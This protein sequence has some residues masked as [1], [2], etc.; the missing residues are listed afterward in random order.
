M[1]PTSD[2]SQKD[3][4]YR[5]VLG[6]VFAIGFLVRLYAYHHTYIINPDGILYI[7]QARAIFNGQWAEVFSCGQSNLTLYPLLIVGLYTIVPDWL[8]AAKGVSFL[9]GFLTLVPVAPFWGR[10]TC[11]SRRAHFSV[12]NRIPSKRFACLASLTKSCRN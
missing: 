7:N 11:A 12:C 6:G 10:R 5:W 9:F 4:D 8:L 2:H 1:K 3:W